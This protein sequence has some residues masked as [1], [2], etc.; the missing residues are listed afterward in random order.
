MG[1]SVRGDQR[2][3]GRNVK[4]SQGDEKNRKQA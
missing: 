3:D 1:D 2:N 4:E